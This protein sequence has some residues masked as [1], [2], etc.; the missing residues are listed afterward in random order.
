MDEITIMFYYFYLIN[1]KEKC[2]REVVSKKPK[3]KRRRRVTF[4]Y[5]DPAPDLQLP[6]VMM[7]LQLL[8]T[9]PRSASVSEETTN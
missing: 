4:W 3:K 9:L 1:E 5:S 2:K 7:V 8:Q 6:L